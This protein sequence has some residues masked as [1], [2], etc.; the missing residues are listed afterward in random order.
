M[1][2]YLAIDYGR[3]YV[4]LALATTSIAEPLQ[5]VPTS[6]AFKSIESLIAKHSITHI[7]VGLSE[8]TMAQ[9]TRQ[10]GE[11]I[12]Q[13]TKIPVIYQDETLSSY[14]TR[15]KSAQAKLK[16]SRREAKQDHFVAA[17]ILQDYLDS[18]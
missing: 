15:L 16:K 3:A 5:T 2:T 12:H 9:E 14:E 17:A 6:Q 10:F 1:K 11:S 13:T 4:G 8:G 7:I 18:Q